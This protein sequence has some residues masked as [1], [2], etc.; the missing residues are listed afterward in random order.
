MVG[1]V[2]VALALASSTAVAAGAPMGPRDVRRLKPGVF[3]YAAPGVVGGA[4]TESVVLLIRHEEGGSMGL[5][6]NRP[7]KV[8]L[9]DAVKALGESREL[10]APLYFGGPVQADG[11]LALVRSAKV[12]GDATQA[13]PGV[14]LCTDLG[15]VKKAARGPEADQ[16]LRVYAGHA[17]WSA[18]QLEDEMRAGA[19]VVAPADAASVFSSDPAS[20]WPRVHDLMRRIEVRAEWR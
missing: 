7:T 18:G 4:F 14:Y 20:L 2:L 13:L 1:N 3:L 12:V 17:G 15:P 6:V 8:R 10:A 9:S 5:I 19:W 11:I 16:R